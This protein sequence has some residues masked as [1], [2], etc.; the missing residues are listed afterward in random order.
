MIWL[1]MSLTK[2]SV[3]KRRTLFLEMGLKTIMRK[4]F[5]VVRRYLNRLHKRSNAQKRQ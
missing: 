1:I 4:S 3:K 5:Q 2:P